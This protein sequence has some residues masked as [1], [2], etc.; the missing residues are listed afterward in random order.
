MIRTLRVLLQKKPTYGKSL[1]NLVFNQT[2]IIEDTPYSG[3]SLSN[4]PVTVTVSRDDCSKPSYYCD[5]TSLVCV[6]VKANGEPCIEE[7]ECASVSVT[8]LIILFSPLS[9]RLFGYRLTSLYV[10][11]DVLPPEQTEMCCVP[12]CG[13]PIRAD[14]CEDHSSKRY[15]LDTIPTLLYSQY[16][17]TGTILFTLI[18][19]VIT[20]LSLCHRRQRAAR[21]KEREL[22]FSEQAMCVTSSLIPH[23]LEGKGCLS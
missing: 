9:C 12:I 8:L 19:V 1:A 3:L 7:R 11:L 15:P 21:R 22:Y 20:S 16:S 14:R 13:H 6:D 4:Y 23:H 17:A 10:S 18:T 5:R 2:C